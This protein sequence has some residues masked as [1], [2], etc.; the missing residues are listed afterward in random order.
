[1]IRRP[2]RSTLFPYTTLFR[3]LGGPPDVPRFVVA[4]VVDAIQR[5]PGGPHAHVRQEAGERLPA[6][7]HR[8]ALACVER[9]HLAP[10]LHGLPGPVRGS[11]A[12]AVDRPGL[13]DLAA[14][15]VAELVAS[16]GNGHLR[17]V[18]RRPDE[19]SPRQFHST[20]R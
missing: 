17:P 20:C 2:P 3:S 14:S 12:H 7:A 9:V 19:N 11:S 16:A 1:M 6:I 15:L 18:L 8:D 4:V 5:H 10:P 13:S